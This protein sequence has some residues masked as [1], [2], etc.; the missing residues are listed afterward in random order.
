MCSA[1]LG[2]S[3]PVHIQQIGAGKPSGDVVALVPRVLLFVTLAGP[4]S[5][6]R[7]DLAVLACPGFVRAAPTLSDTTRAG[8]PSAARPCRDRT[9][10]KVSHLCSSC[11][12][13]MAHV[14][15]G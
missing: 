3:H 10:M 8:L 11:W 9:A 5:P 12:P 7:H 4:N 1:D 14:N 6:D 13:L 15:R 2:S